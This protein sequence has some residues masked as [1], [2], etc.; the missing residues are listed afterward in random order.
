MIID[1]RQ[2]LLL[3]IGSAIGVIILIILVVAWPFGGEKAPEQEAPSTPSVETPTGNTATPSEPIEDVFVPPP[4]EDQTELFARQSA[5][6]FVERFLTYSNQNNNEH[7]ED[8]EDLVTARMR[9][10]IRTQKQEEG[11]DYQGVQTQVISSE[12]ENISPE[13]AVVSFDGRQVLQGPTKSESQNISGRVNLTRNG[14]GWL[15]DGL[16]WE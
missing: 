2:R 11:D 15:V 13:S 10:W 7:I 3:I 16:F 6:L 12:I 5:R 14:N 1:L 8:V 9:A 4:T